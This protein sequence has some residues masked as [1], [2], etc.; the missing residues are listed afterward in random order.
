MRTLVTARHLT[1]ALAGILIG[2]TLSGVAYAISAAG[3]RYSAPRTGYL[4]I[5]AAA[6]VPEADTAVYTNLGRSLDVTGIACAVAP[7]NLP[8]GAKMTQLAM[9]YSKD[10]ATETSLSLVRLL[11]ASSTT[12]DIATLNTH[13]TG[14]AV[15]PGH[16]S[17]ANTA[18]Q[19]VSNEQSSYY[20]E[21]CLTDQ[22]R[23]IG[24]RIKYTYTSAGD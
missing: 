13:D 7:V 21:K 5:P 6:F 22:E 23:F 10:D 11:P 8:D 24:A 12:A 18:L 9:W 15:K 3:F 2:F 14:G 20:L 16:V 19:T 4:M 1:I 17:I